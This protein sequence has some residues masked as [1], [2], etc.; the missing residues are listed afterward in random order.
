VKRTPIRALARSISLSI[1]ACLVCFALWFA[2]G[3]S[4]ATTFTVNDTGDTPDAALNGTCADS[5]GKCTLRAA[6][7]EANNVA[8]TDTITFDIAGAGPHTIQLAG[9]LPNLSDSVDILNTS[10]ESVT[11]R[12]NTG[13][14]YGIFTVNSGQTVNINGLTISNGSD[15]G[16][17]GILNSGTLTLTNSTVSGN[18]ANSSGGGI[19]NRG[20]LN[21][22]N[23]TVSGNSAVF[24]GGGIITAN[25]NPT[26]TGVTITDNRADS[27]NNGVGIGGG[28][29]INSGTPLLRSSIVAGN[30]NEDGATDAADDIKG[31]GSADGTSSYNLIGTGGSG[32]LTNGTNNNQVGVANPGLGALQN[33]GGA[34]QTHALLTGSPA[35]DKGKNFAVD[36]GNN[37]VLTDQRGFTRPSDDTSIPPATGGDNSDIGA[38][39]VQ[40]PPFITVAG[41]PLNFPDTAVGSAS[42][43]QT[44][45]VSGGNLTADI[46]VT[47]PS[48]DFR[49]SKT[50]GSG[51]GSSVT[52]T[53]S[54][55]SVATSTVYV[56]FTPQSAGT[57]SGN[58]TNASTAATTQN[59]AVSGTGTFTISGTITFGGNGLSGVTVTLSGAE[60]ATTTTDVGG[61]YTFTV[62]TSGSYIVTPS[63]AHFTFT[64][65]SRT[66]TN[67]ST[68]QTADFTATSTLTEPQ[69]ANGALLIS[70]FRFSGVTTTDEFIELYNNTDT[71][72]GISAYTLSTSDGS[73]ISFPAG[74]SV[75][76]RG[77]Y[78]VANS[79]G[80]TLANYGGTGI[81]AADTTYTGF[82]IPSNAGVALLDA[83]SNI[84]DAVGFTTSPAPY[85]E[86]N[87]LATTAGSGQYSFVRNMATTGLPHDAGDNASDFML[88]ATD[89]TAITGSVLGAPGPE[90]ITSPVNRGGSIKASLFAPCLPSSSS[91]N[92]VRDPN[93]Y[94][95]TVTPSSPD[96][97]VTPSP[98]PYVSGVMKIRRRFTNNTG[99]T[100]TTLRFRV[101]DMTAGTSSI[102]GTADIHLLTSSNEAATTILNT[103]NAISSTGLTLEQPPTQTRGGG[104]NST[105]VS[106]SV[107]AGGLAPSA[108]I[109]IN[110]LLGVQTPG[111][112][113]FFVI[114]EALPPPTSPASSVAPA[115][116]LDSPKGSLP[117]RQK[118][119]PGATKGTPAKS[120]Q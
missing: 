75:S 22:T 84:V 104:L 20:T 17:G 25:V 24:S 1:F 103:C 56:R 46:T 41:G 30:F 97:V 10:G 32:G 8:G 99:Q 78:L 95:D 91:P 107:A 67:V 70:E 112:F 27:D 53:P 42:A 119:L 36:A 85:K 52:F 29:F 2:W 28:I 79:A 58:I 81:A 111:S 47:A 72:V 3:A 9:A 13:G 83:S 101:V 63:K 110:F 100:V 64:P 23:S 4:A 120:D 88:V 118:S 50:S 116:K 102:S 61:H 105:V 65:T 44:Y 51:F 71:A 19:N 76:A 69:P 33:N 18:S 16:G 77:H 55:G 113:R 54:G 12:R 31:S 57:K 108:T 38:F 89:P 11:V 37:P 98:T 5:N 39:E 6:I 96:G 92:R 106:R 15:F 35:I 34:T 43:E 68:N 74:A 86:G 109:D 93:P 90:N 7:Q 114:V 94:T 21:V 14:N 115:S 45:T 40:N 26:L 82:D 59:V 80:Y 49:V 87:G 48:T 117:T 73:N 60:S 62:S 66:L